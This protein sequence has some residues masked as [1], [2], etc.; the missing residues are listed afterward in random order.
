MNDSSTNSEKVLKFRPSGESFRYLEFGRFR[1]DTEDRQLFQDGELVSLPPKTVELLVALAERQGQLVTKETLMSTLWPDTFVEDGNLT[2][3]ISR[4]RKALDNGSGQ[5]E[6]IETIPRRGYRFVAEVRPAE[7]QTGPM[8]RSRKSVRLTWPIAIGLVAI[9]AIT[10]AIVRLSTSSKPSPPAPISPS[11]NEAYLKGRYHFSKRTISDFHKAVE[12]FRSAVEQEPRFA[13]AWA[14]LADVYNFLGEGA[15]AKVAARRALEID[16]RLV[17]AHTAI[18]HASLF[19]DFDWATSERHFKRAIHLDPSYSS[20]HHWYAFHLAGRGRFDEALT[21]I[22]QARRLEPLS[23]IINTDAAQILF[24]ARRYD[25]AIARFREVLK[26]DSSFVQAHHALTWTYIRAGDHQAAAMEL[27]SFA[28]PLL[29]V[30]ELDAAAGRREKAL[31]VL[32]KLE[33]SSR[34]EQ[35]SESEFGIA[36][37]H[38]ALGNTPESLAWLE[39]ARV[40]RDGNLVTVQV[41]PGFDPIRDDPRFRVFVERMGL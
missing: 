3:H 13:L 18:A 33:E 25:E 37:L 22:E 21:E 17:Q 11:A 30:G 16:E 27:Q 2:Q 7:G 39:K 6:P 41:D 28:N 5:A 36:R 26:L 14:G 1:L 15:R 31:Q 35:S 9:L 10:A 12:H 34:T 38:A 8:L 19:H 20:A 32:Q 24:Y 29:L 40:N 23:L 4:L